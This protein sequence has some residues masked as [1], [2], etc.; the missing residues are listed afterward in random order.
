MILQ[1]Y[2]SR[3]SVLWQQL[4]ANIPNA[5]A[6]GFLGNKNS[7]WPCSFINVIITALWI[8]PFS[9]HFYGAESVWAAYGRFL[10]AQGLQKISTHL[11]VLSVRAN[12]K[13]TCVPFSRF[14]KWSF[15]EHFCESCRRAKDARRSNFHS[16]STLWNVNILYAVCMEMSELTQTGW[17]YTYV[18]QSSFCSF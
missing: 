18:L 3:A 1:I 17:S 6:A 8:Y 11:F 14:T 16:N 15:N 9:Q 2:P 12:F 7:P 5:A 4:R 10:H 13:R